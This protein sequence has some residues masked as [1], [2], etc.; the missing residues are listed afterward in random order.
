MRDNILGKEL[1]RL[2]K[3][4]NF[5]QEEVAERLHVIRQTYSHYET[6]RVQ[7][8]VKKLYELA[9]LYETPIT[10]LLNYMD[11]TGMEEISEEIGVVLSEQEYELLRYSRRLDEKD[12]KD[13]LRLTKKCGGGKTGIFEKIRSQAMKAGFGY[14]IVQPVTVR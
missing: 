9:M 10:E 1:K 12:R 14:C 3:E 6:G 4:K 13:I 5:S 8:P 11:D 2:R 7:P